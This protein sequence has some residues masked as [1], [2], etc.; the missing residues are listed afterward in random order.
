MH[1]KIDWFYITKTQNKTL[2]LILH[3]FIRGLKV[4]IIIHTSTFRRSI[5]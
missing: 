3:D 2:L 4:P 1:Q 5:Y